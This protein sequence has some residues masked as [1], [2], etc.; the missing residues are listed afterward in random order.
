MPHLI[1]ELSSNLE[2]LAD[3]MLDAVTDACQQTGLFTEAVF[4]SRVVVHQ[5]YRV[6][7]HGRSAFV[8]MTLRIRPGRT[9]ETK[10]ALAQQLAQVAL[11]IIE[12]AAEAPA[13]CITCEIQEVDLRSR[14]LIF[15]GEG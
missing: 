3:D 13:T 5:R 8:G 14:A 7:Q 2:P 9:P 10:E 1:L 11:R 12:S 6:R 4:M 15:S